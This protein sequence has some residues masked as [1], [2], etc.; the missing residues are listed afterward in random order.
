MGTSISVPSSNKVP[1]VITH[2]ALRLAGR[3]RGVEDVERVVRRDRH[4]A[5][6]RTQGNNKLALVGHRARHVQLLVVE[7]DDGVVAD[8]DQKHDGQRDMHEHPAGQEPPMAYLHDLVIEQP[9]R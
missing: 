7:R 5:M 1:S 4:A 6:R 3:A 2:D 8:Q 9:H